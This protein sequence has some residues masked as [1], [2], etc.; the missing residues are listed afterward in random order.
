ME[1]FK[2]LRFVSF[3][4]VGRFVPVE[5]FFLGLFEE[6]RLLSDDVGFV[7][8]VMTDYVNHRRF[9]SKDE[10][11]EERGSETTLRLIRSPRASF[12]PTGTGTVTFGCC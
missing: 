7:E 10:R 1:G 9:F 12:T 5:A 3:E 11:G 2:D 8:V 6:I 4:G